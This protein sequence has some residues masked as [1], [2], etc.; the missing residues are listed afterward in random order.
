M[1]R[2][3]IHSVKILLKLSIMAKLVLPAKLRIFIHEAVGNPVK[4]VYWLIKGMMVC[5]ALICP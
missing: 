5:R 4:A 3:V 1:P 2:P